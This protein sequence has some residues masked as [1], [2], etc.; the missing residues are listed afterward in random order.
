MV[1]LDQLKSRHIGAAL[2]MSGLLAVALVGCGKSKE[3]S[4]PAPSTKEADQRTQLLLKL[5]G[6][7]TD[8]L[9]EA[10]KANF[11]DPASA[12]LQDVATYVERIKFK[13][14]TTSDPLQYSVCGLVNAKNSYGGYVGFRSFATTVT[15]NL[16]GQPAPGTMFVYLEQPDRESEAKRFAADRARICADNEI[17]EEEVLRKR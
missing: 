5:K 13:D 15:V 10:L 1:P 8:M 9:L 14:G 2:W 7:Y 17:A 11:K 12:Q 4:P 6:V 16:E 3:P